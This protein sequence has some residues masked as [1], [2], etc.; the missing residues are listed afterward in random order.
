MSATLKS[1]N[2]LKNSEYEKSQ[3][4]N[5]QPISYVAEMDIVTPKEDPQVLKV[6]LPDDSHIN[7]RATEGVRA[8]P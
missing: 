4:S 5:R 6:K 1:P 8:Y 7:I 2:G 3:L